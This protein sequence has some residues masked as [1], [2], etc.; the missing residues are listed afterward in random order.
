MLDNTRYDCFAYENKCGEY[1]RALKALY[2]KPT[3]EC[4]FYKE[5][6]FYKEELKKCAQRLI[7]LEEQSAFNNNKR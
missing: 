7:E 6:R 5:K 1:C 2:C 3:G 4:K